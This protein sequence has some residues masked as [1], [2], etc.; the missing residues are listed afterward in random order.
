[1]GGSYKGNSSGHRGR[2]YGLMLLVAFGAALIGVMVL[3]KLRERRIFDLLVQQKDRDLISLQLFLQKEREYSKEMKRKNEEMKAKIYS[4][5][6][7]KMELDRRILEKQSTIDSLKD[8]QRTV[9]SAIEEKQNEIKMLRKK[10]I[11]PGKE[12]PQVIALMESLKQKEAE[13]EDLKHRLEHPVKV[14]SVSTDDPS[15]PSMNLTV[16]GSVAGQDQ[17]EVIKIKEEQLT[18]RVEDGIENK[19]GD[20]K[21]SQDEGLKNEGHAIEKPIEDSQDGGDFGIGKRDNEM[22]VMEK[23]ENSQEYDHKEVNGIHKSGRRLEEPDNS[24]IGTSSRMRGKHGHVSKSTKGKRWRKLMKNRWLENNKEAVSLRSRNSFKED[25]DGLK[26]R[27][28][29]ATSNDPMEV[30]K[31]DDSLDGKSMKPQNHEDVKESILVNSDTNHQVVNGREMLKNPHNSTNEE[32]QLLKN[33]SGIN[34]EVSN[35]ITDVRKWHSTTEE[36]EANGIQKNTS[37]SNINK[38][39]ED[40]E[41]ASID[42]TNKVPEDL[43]VSN[44]QESEKEEADGDGDNFKESNSD[45]E[46]EYI[47]ETEE[48]EF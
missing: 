28:E 17:T 38:V 43:E 31:V 7:Q 15:N 33:G 21:N 34:G 2:P 29:G 23:F 30:R 47:E 8:E 16:N 26:G 35:I 25:Q 12:N 44:I 4:L 22:K 18:A 42:D 14:W 5:R 37:S 6:T 27:T 32:V 36:H 3:H 48:S 11:D 13:I 46:E 20:T 41:Q 10:E 19:A 45:L 40:A 1:M 9:E 39:E 24:N